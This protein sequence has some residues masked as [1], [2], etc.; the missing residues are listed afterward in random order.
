MEKIVSSPQIQR[1]SEWED[2]D[3][4]VSLKPKIRRVIPPARLTSSSEKGVKKINS[5]VLKSLQ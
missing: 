1:A 2:M 3:E 5:Y 4:I